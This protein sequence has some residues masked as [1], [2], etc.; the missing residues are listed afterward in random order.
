MQ[1][2]IILSLFYLGVTETLCLAEIPSSRRSRAAISRVKADLGKQLTK[3]GFAFGNPLFIRIVKE[4]R[5]LELFLKPDG[6]E[7]FKL[8][9][10]YPIC[11]F[12]GELGPKQKQ[13]DKQSPEGFYFVRPKQLNPYSSFH[14]SFNLGYPNAFDRAHG[15]TGSALMVHGNCV[16]IGCYAM[17]DPVIEEIFA[18]IDAAFRDGQAFFRVHIF[19]FEMSEENLLLHAKSPWFEF[20]KSLKLGYDFFEGNKLPPNIVVRDKKYAIQSGSLGAN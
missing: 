10:K 7:V 17:T 19:P 9:K 6:S 20:W 8:F 13:G 5:S 15:R 4:S 14:L 3:A 11:A 12:S 16:S 2:I 1:F 18:I